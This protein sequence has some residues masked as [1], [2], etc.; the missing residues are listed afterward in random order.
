MCS[1]NNSNKSLVEKYYKTAEQYDQ[2]KETQGWR[3]PDIV[4]GMVYQF[5]KS[6]QLVLDI[7]IG[8]GLGSILF[9][10]AGL[11]VCGMDLSVDM[12]EVCRK[13]GF[14]EDL[15]QH[16]LKVIPYPYSDEMFDH[17]V[18]VG[19]LNHFDDL[20]PVF[21]ETSRIL[22]K[23]G[24]FTFIAA[25]RKNNEE[26]TFN[27]EHENSKTT[28]FRYSSE[29]IEKLLEDTN[30]VLMKQVEFMVPGHKENNQSMRLK[31]YT[32]KKIT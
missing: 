30:F 11:R 1:E 22:K 6:G 32:A 16:D 9:H 15:Q 8:T 10:K 31:T 18:C 2:M 3:G 14:T 19:V 25:D 4:F 13:K 17:A 12:L 23:N 24:T 21:S 26:H 29:E 28:M 5:I 27:V 20:S 7:G